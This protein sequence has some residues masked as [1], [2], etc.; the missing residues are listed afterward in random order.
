MRL[1]A[2]MKSKNTGAVPVSCSSRNS[3]KTCGSFVSQDF[4]LLQKGFKQLSW[5]RKPFGAGITHKNDTVLPASSRRCAR[6]SIAKTSI[7]MFVIMC[8]CG[9]DCHRYSSTSSYFGCVGNHNSVQCKVK[10]RK[11]TERKSKYSP[12]S[13]HVYT[14][15]HSFAVL[16]H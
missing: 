15:S 4:L 7:S 8:G 3:S 1:P 11:R 6:W 10:S 12:D 9:L 16:S 13:F 5:K 14:S 2:S